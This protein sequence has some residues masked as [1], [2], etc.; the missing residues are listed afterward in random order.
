MFLVDQIKRSIDPLIHPTIFLSL[1]QPN[2][3]RKLKR[4]QSLYTHL[5]HLKSA[6]PPLQYEKME[7]KPVENLLDLVNQFSIILGW[8]EQNMAR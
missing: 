7:P 4:S 3:S 2:Q 1:T 5:G 6:L 8:T